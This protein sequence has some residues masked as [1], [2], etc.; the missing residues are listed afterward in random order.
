MTVNTNR[1][2]LLLEHPANCRL[3]GQWLGERYEVVI[4]NPSDGLDGPFDLA[5]LDGLG[6]EKQG[7]AALVDRKR[8]EEPVFL[9]YLLVASRRD[10]GMVT[11]HLWRTVDELLLAPVQKVELQARVEILLRT[12]RLSLELSLRNTDLEALV[13]AVTHELR[14]PLRAISGFT[15]IL[16]EEHAA[17]LDEQGRK[18]LER[19]VSSANDMS[20]LIHSLLSF[21]RIGAEPAMLEPIPVETVIRG[22]LH[23]LA[24]EIEAQQAEVTMEGDLSPTVRTDPVLLQ[25]ILTNLLTNA[26]KFIAP[27]VR[28]RVTITVSCAAPWCHIAIRDNGIGIAPQDQARIFRPFG[29]LHSVDDYPGVGLGLATAQK[30]AL[31]IGA[32]LGMESVPGQGSTFWVEVEAVP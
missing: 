22:S 27:G 21:A 7:E 18:D 13:R 23:R 15:H 8:V 30:A 28:P 6:L 16:V 24:S 9:P 26:I 10:V 2:L 20:K 32:R 17:R 12:R 19:I 11:R 31:W 1:I 25:M 5:I 4:C 3:L 14:G 29:R